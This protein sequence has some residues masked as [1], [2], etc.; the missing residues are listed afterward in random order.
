MHAH[1]HAEQYS[2]EIEHDVY[3]KRQDEIL[4]L[5]KHGET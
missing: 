4:F 3:F 5:P 1:A 2:K